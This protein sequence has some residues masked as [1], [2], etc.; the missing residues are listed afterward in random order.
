MPAQARNQ[1]VDLE[2]AFVVDASGS[3]DDDE[4]FYSYDPED[5]PEDGTLYSDSGSSPYY[6]IQAQSL[7][8]EP[9]KNL[10][11]IRVTITPKGE[12]SEAARQNRT[13]VLN[14][15]RSTKYNE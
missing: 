9:L 14:F 13:V 4:T 8:G 15:I 6:D 1:A 10:T 11:T 5:Y 3:I 12:K 7:G 2:L